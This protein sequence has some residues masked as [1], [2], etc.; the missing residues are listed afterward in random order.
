MNTY[1]FKRWNWVRDRK[2]QS[3]VPDR[4]QGVLYHLSFHGLKNM[5]VLAGSLKRTEKEN[6]HLC[7][8][9]LPLMPK[10][11]VLT[12]CPRLIMTYGSLDITSRTAKSVPFTILTLINP[13]NST[14]PTSDWKKKHTINVEVT[15]Q[16][17]YTLTKFSIG[18]FVAPFSLVLCYLNLFSSSYSW[19]HD[20]NHVCCYCAAGV[21]LVHAF[22]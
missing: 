11:F 19:K 14:I 18:E 3:F 1:Q 4:I 10:K 17:P 9:K 7:N 13:T 15:Y 20:Q 16:V 8:S 6:R 21:Y 2:H 12:W 22:Y 5:N